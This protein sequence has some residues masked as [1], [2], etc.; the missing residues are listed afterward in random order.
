M[1]LAPGETPQMEWVRYRT[2]GCY[3]LTGAIRVPRGSVSSDSLPSL[4][5]CSRIRFESFVEIPMRPVPLLPAA[6][7][8]AIAAGD[9]EDHVKVIG[10]LRIS[11]PLYNVYLNEADEW[12]RRLQVETSEWALELHRPLPDSIVAMAHSL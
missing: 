4:P 1:P 2:L 9:T 5:A 12:S 6:D 3:P 8:S 7:V 10:D 11:I